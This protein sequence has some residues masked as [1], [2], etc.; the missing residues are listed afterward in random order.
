MDD[1]EATET[2]WEAP[3]AGSHP[4]HPA[5]QYLA[6]RRFMEAKTCLGEQLATAIYANLLRTPTGAGNILYSKHDIFAEPSIVSGPKSLQVLEP[7]QMS[8]DKFAKD[9]FMPCST[10]YFINITFNTF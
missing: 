10:L 6:P 7:R 8:S 9:S 4:P 1:K 2:E 5:L 3:K